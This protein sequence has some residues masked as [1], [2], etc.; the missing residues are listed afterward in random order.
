LIIEVKVLDPQPFAGRTALVTGCSRRI[1][2][3]FAIAN[4]LAALGA[5]LFVHAY[6]AYDAQQPWGGDPD[7]LPVLMQEL[8]SHGHRVEQIEADF[9]EPDAPQQV[10]DAAVQAFGHLDILVANHA[11]STMGALEE[12]VAEEIDRH[13][14]VN[15]RASLLLAKAFAAQ[16]DGR[17]GGRIVLMT[18]GQHLS[19]MPAELAYIASKGALHQLTLSLAAHL[20]PRGITVN[21]VNP[22]A[23]DTGYATPAG[24]A[25][26]LAL[27][28]QGR[29][30]RPDDAARLIAWLCTDDAQW[31]TGQVIN[32]TGGGP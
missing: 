24:H 14:L 30:G 28:P 12:L 19:P 8:R 3:G 32:S 21:T 5:D 9:L 20:A 7:G 4:R 23:T 22:G 31:I 15:V 29:W 27:E 1:G 25:A 10:M 26:V 2:I 17:P 13:L 11:Y 18:S 6:A 16:H